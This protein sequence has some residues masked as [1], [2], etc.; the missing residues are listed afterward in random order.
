MEVQLMTAPAPDAAD[1]RSAMRHFAGNVSV[2]TVGAGDRRSGLVATSTVSLSV[3]PPLMLV[4]VN[5]NSSS[6]PLF[7][8]FGHFGVNS[9]APHHQPIAERFTGQGGVKGADRFALGKWR[10]G[11][12]GAPL[13][14]GAAVAL[15]CEIEEMIEKSTH[16]ILI[17]RVRSIE[18]GEAKGALIYWKGGYRP[19]DTVSP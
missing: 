18:I 2:I 15:D 3:D 1:Y 4:C 17:G 11:L 13:L 8:A 6:W 16:A 5:R 12:T 19:I 14:D 9:L 10:S 7:D